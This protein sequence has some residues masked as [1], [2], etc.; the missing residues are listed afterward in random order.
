MLLAPDDAVGRLIV[1]PVLVSSADGWE[2][3]TIQRLRDLPSTID[4]PIVGNEVLVGH[5]AG[6][7][8]VE[9]R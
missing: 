5:L 6:P 3:V 1:S 7:F 4:I 9:A 2:G 8:L